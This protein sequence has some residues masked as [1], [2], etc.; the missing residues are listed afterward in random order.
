MICNLTWNNAGPTAVST[1][2][3]QVTCV[4]VLSVVQIMD[5]VYAGLGALVFA[6]VS[7]VFLLHVSVVG[8]VW[9]ETDTD[10][11]EGAAALVLY[12]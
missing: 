10:L 2:G 6:L 5:T 9:D 3:N 1:F 12:F 7:G 8:I 11:T 4:A